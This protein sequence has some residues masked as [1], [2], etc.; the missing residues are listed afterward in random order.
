MRSVWSPYIEW[1]SVSLVG[2]KLP[3]RLHLLCGRVHFYRAGASPEAEVSVKTE[4]LLARRYTIPCTPE[5]ASKVLDEALSGQVV[6]DGRVF[7]L[8]C[9]Q[10]VRLTF[11]ERA[12]GFTG[13]ARIPGC[14]IAG[15]PVREVLEKIGGQEA[16]EW[17]LRGHSDPYYGL[18]QLLASLGLPVTAAVGDLTRLDVAI[19]PPVII[20]GDQSTI[21]AGRAEVTLTASPRLDTGDISVNVRSFSPGRVLGNARTLEFVSRAPH[22]DAGDDVLVFA[23]DVGEETLVHVFL[24]AKGFAANQFWITDQARRLHGHIAVAE[25][26]DESLATLDRYLKNARGDQ[27]DLFE[28]AIA[29][30]A[31]LLGFR[32][33]WLGKG[34]PLTDGPDLLALTTTGNVLVAECTVGHPDNKDK[35]AKVIQRAARVREKLS[36]S[37]FPVTKVLPIVATPLPRVELK[38]AISDAHRRGVLVLDAE[39]LAK[40]RQ[41]ITFPPDSDRRFDEAMSALTSGAE[42]DAAPS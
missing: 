13:D 29:T 11:P 40:L 23:G 38:D 7:D 42:T 4:H 22:G 6:L 36:K 16:A 9:A 27:A 1:I 25:V 31:T 5:I 2:V 26:F 19:V 20:M 33:L 37:G 15:E 30:L 41:Q 35:V 32:V 14:R 28:W 8:R 3:D 10:L 17:E 39:A 18:D 21:R 24:S 34:T 12:P